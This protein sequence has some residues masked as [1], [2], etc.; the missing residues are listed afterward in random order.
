[1]KYRSL[2]FMSPEGEGGGAAVAELPPMEPMADIFKRELKKAQPESAKEPA[3]VTGA[4]GPS[5]PDPLG[6]TG[7]KAQTGATGAA[8]TGVSGPAKS[9]LDAV[10]EDSVVTGPTGVT[11]PEDYLK[12]LPETLP[13]EGRGEHWSKARGVIEKQG[14]TIG[15]L[16]KTIAELNGQLAT[17]KATPPESSTRLAEVEAERDQYKDILTAVNVKSHPDFI[18]E[19]VDGR[20]ALVAK[21]ESKLNAFGGK[22]ELI[23]Q[24]LDMAEGRGRTQAIKDALE[25]L[26]AVEQNRVLTFVT[27]VEKLDDRRAEQEAQIEKDPYGPWAKLQASEKARADAAIAKREDFKKTMFDKM[28]G[29]LPKSHFLLREVST[30]V[31]D[32]IAHNETVKTMRESAFALLG[33]NAKPEDLI[34]AAFAKQELPRLQE[35]LLSSRK[36]LATALSTLKEYETASPGFR[37]GKKPAESEEEQKMKKT[38]G[39]IYNEDLERQRGGQE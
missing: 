29:E 32:A 6:T 24:A 7:V 8:A 33:P 13:R 17:A 16:H 18:K 9:A 5:D 36:E 31:P 25:G 27:E 3:G 34:E 12:D 30:D 35:L 10:L 37:G 22:G 15:Q 21:A 23:A 28:A 20:R 1:M 26:E 4:K 14:G 39:Q 2:K 19:F 38:P 11:A